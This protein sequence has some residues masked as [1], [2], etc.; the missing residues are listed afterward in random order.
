MRSVARSYFMSRKPRSISPPGLPGPLENDASK[1]IEV[2][3]LTKF[4]KEVHYAFAMRTRKEGRYPNEVYYTT[5][6]LMYVGKYIE[7]ERWGWGDGSGGA[8][9]FDNN[10]KQERIEYDYEGN[11]CFVPVKVININ[12][13]GS[14]LFRPLNELEENE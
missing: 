1:E 4:D 11:T 5:N 10:G 6:P 12:E 2:Y 14:V 13:D 8:E 7:S 3:R 9:Y